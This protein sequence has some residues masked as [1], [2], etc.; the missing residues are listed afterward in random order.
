MQVRTARRRADILG[1]RVD[2]VTMAEAVAL[3]LGW[4]AEREPRLVVTP[5]PEIV[6]AAR[7]DAGFLRHTLVSI[8][9]GR[10]HV[11]WKPVSI[12][13]WQPGERTF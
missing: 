12:T 1:V 7:D 11:G 10:V 2:D 5:N 3:V 13:T 9:D 8:H 6:M 4:T